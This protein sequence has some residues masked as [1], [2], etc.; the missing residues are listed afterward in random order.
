MRYAKQSC[1]YYVYSVTLDLV[2]EG[3]EGGA[4]IFNLDKK[5]RK[6]VDAIT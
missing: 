5:K 6:N 2:G 4:L 3:R 1:M